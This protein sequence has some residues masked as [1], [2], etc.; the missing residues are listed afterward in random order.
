MAR[1]FVRTFGSLR[2]PP[3]RHCY[4]NRPI[5]AS[6]CRRFV[7]RRRTSEIVMRQLLLVPLLILAPLAAIQAQPANGA[8]P[9]T[10]VLQGGVARWSGADARECGIQGRRYAAVDGICYYP[11]DMRAKTGIHE[12]ALW[13]AAGARQLG[14]LTVATRDCTETAITLDRLQYI[15]VSGEDRARAAKERQHVL[16][17]VKG[18]AAVHPRFSLP[19]AAPAKG[20]GDTDRSDFC[21]RRLYND[22]IRSVHTGLD[23]PIGRG[24]AVKS[25][26]DGTVVLADTHF[27]SGRTVMVDHGGGLM[28]MVFHLDEIAVETGAEIKRGEPLGAVGD[29]GR[30]TGPHLHFG[31]RWHDQRID[32]AALLGDPVRLPGIGETPQAQ[33]AADV[34]AVRSDAVLSSP[35]DAAGED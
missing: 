10:T 17:A 29:S 16:A 5:L 28:T 2:V 30:A 4:P 8:V 20:A 31:A 35:E 33:A 32:A 15:D 14:T 9:G 23:Y 26:A 21:E 6:R 24:T 12:V 11:V 25:P 18:V 34:K 7:R 27:Y 13:D 22:S 1:E 3:H 19:L